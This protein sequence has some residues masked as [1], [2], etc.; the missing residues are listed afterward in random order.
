M[1]HVLFAGGGTGGHLYPALALAAALQQERPDVE[2]HFVGAKRGVESQVLPA[3]N[4]PHTLLPFEPLRRSKVWQNWRLFPSMWASM[5]GLRTLFDEFKPVLVVGTGGYAS[6]PACLFALTRRVP[7]AV[8]EQNSHPGLTTRTLGRWA[9][10]VHLGF[11]EAGAKINAGNH[12]QVTALGNP[13]RKPDPT[14]DRAECRNRF[15]LRS[16]SRVVLVVGGSQGSRAINEALLGAIARSHAPTLPRSIE[17][18]WA[19]GPN[20]IE[21]ISGRLSA[22]AKQWVHAFG[23]I[24]NMSEALA[25]ADVAISRAG[26]MGTAEL[27]A[28]GIPMILIPLPTAAADHQTHNARALANA[29]AA[30]MLDE[31]KLTPDSLWQSLMTLVGDESTLTQMKRAALARAQPNAAQEIARRLAEL[32]P[33]TDLPAAG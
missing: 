2:V 7:V 9:R 31:R 17:I 6:A 19:T 25:S 13:I 28:W 5:R 14:L 24:H 12:T 3:E 15:G 22:E 26:A 4:Q 32:L 11:P 16:D 30:L 33:R 10:Q 21:N 27:L 1:S 20:H 18:L 8:Q 29:S 23:Y